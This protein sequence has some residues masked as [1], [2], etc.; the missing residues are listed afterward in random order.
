MIT[1]EIKMTALAKLK[2][3]VPP[4]EIAEELDIPLP[5][6]KEWANTIEGNDLIQLHA[7]VHAVTKL[8]NGEIT[9]SNNEEFLRLKIEEV[10][11]DI[12]EQVQLV[13]TGGDVVRAK[14]LQLCADTVTKL[15]NSLINNIT[16]ADG[17]LKP[18]G[19]EISAFKSLMKD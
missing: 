1:K 8:A 12:V 19:Q 2:C 13:T 6:I 9:R 5:L 16:N 11:I 18:N 10:A 14:A 7:N 3:Q 4:E 17:S 15:Y